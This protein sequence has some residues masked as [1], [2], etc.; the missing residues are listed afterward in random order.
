MPHKSSYGGKK[1][2]KSVKEKSEMMHKM[3]SGMMMKNK[4][5]KSMKKNM[6]TKKK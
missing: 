2:S 3:P 6:K 4:E 1:P 5:M